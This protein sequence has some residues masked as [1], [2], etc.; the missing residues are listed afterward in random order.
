[1]A[2]VDGHAGGGN[3]QHR[4]QPA[5]SR[6]QAPTQIVAH[7]GILTQLIAMCGREQRRDEEGGFESA[8]RASDTPAAVTGDTAGAQ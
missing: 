7:L 4:C 3:R 6:P 5:E 8:D 1:M 2:T